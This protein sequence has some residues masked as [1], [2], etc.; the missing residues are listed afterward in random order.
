MNIDSAKAIKR[1]ILRF[2]VVGL[3]SSTFSSNYFLHDS[4][5]KYTSKKANR[6]Y[7]KNLAKNLE[8]SEIQNSLFDLGI[9]KAR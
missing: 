5:P 3:V 8:K 1:R 6:E 9:K 4:N 7:L 2:F